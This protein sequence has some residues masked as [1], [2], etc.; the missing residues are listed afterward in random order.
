MNI[1]SLQELIFY[2]F[3]YSFL[4]WTLENVHSLIITSKFFK[5]SFLNGPFKPMYGFTSVF[6]IIYYYKY[7]SM[8]LFCILALI[9]PTS[10]EY[11]TG[12]SLKKLLNKQYWDYSDF[13]FQLNSYICL[14]FCLYWMLLSIIGIMLLHPIINYIYHLIYILWDFTYLIF[15]FYIFVDFY[16]SILAYR[17][18]K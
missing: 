16:T 2:F 15:L 7:H 4:G 1:F 9:I 17:T 10:I 5:D 14:R 12:F 3:V 13:R 18:N 11:F 6:L 8:L